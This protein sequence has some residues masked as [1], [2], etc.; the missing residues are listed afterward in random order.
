MLRRACGVLGLLLAVVVA[1]TGSSAASSAGTGAPTPIDLGTL[2]GTNSAATGISDTGEVVGQ[3]QVR[4]DAQWHGFAWTPGGGIVDIPTLGGT[5]ANAFGVNDVGEVAGYS[6]LAGDTT[7]HA[8]Y[9]SPGTGTIDVGTLGG[10][11]S[12]IETTANEPT[13]K[14]INSN[15]EIVGTSTLPGE[16]VFHAFVWTRTGGI[17]DLGTLGGS[18][19]TGEAINDNGV[20]VGKSQIAGDAAWH[21]FS[22][23]PAAGMKDL[24]TS[25][26]SDQFGDSPPDVA[27]I[28]A[29]GQVAGLSTLPGDQTYDAVIW[30]AATGLKDL[31]TGPGPGATAARTEDANGNVAGFLTSA[32][33]EHHAMY[34]SPSGGMVDLGTLG[35]GNYSDASGMNSSGQVVGQALDAN[36]RSH[37]FEWTAD[38]GMIDLPAPTSGWVASAIE[39]NA[40][41][42]VVGA[43]SVNGYPYTTHAVLWQPVSVPGQPSSVTA[44]AGPESAAVSWLAPTSDGGSSITGYTVTA[45][46]ATT[47]TD[48]QP[49]AV[50][51]TS[52]TVSNL[53]DGHAYTFTVIAQNLVG[54]GPSSQPSNQVVP[55][56]ADPTPVSVTSTAAASTG[57]TASTGSDPSTTGGV[58]TTVTVP[59][60]TGGGT[61]TVTQGAINQTAPTGYS[62]GGTQV[63]ITAPTASVS[64]PLS[65]VFTVALPPGYPV[66]PATGGP[67]QAT[68]LATDIYRAE[69]SG[70]PQAIPSCVSTS[71]IDP[72]P[73]CVSDRSAVQINGVWYVRVTVLA[74][75]ASHWNSARPSPAAVTVASGGYTPSAAI[76]QI[77]GRVNWTFTGAKQHSVTDSAALGASSAPLFDSGSKNSGTYGY[78]FLAAGNYGYKSTVKGDSMTG[79]VQVP[80][81]VTHPGSTY[82]VVWAAAKI[83]GYVFDVQYRF[84]PTGS[85]KWGSWTTWQNGASNP[86]AT[87]TPTQGSGTYS[88]HARIRNTTTGKASGDSPEATITIP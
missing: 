68:I 62:F 71:P 72:L 19:S 86:D 74:T 29:S 56:A 55:Q 7:T 26:G 4:G 10:T 81:A 69:G 44:V 27:A 36:N 78:A 87:F 79:S 31:G 88:F 77:G 18:N 45:H 83:T 48:G 28:N 8:F 80:I 37:A 3:S 9:W 34:W 11:Y 61:I 14:L 35:G 15:G 66:D 47:S 67:D 65:L 51:G 6:S 53:I 50:S 60:G 84:K 20:V 13:M 85:T 2:G 32:A 39:I 40:N 52:T 33:N 63:D 1:V 75:S 59:P 43:A 57:G 30:T 23:T 58:T 46:D 49:L 76:V 38:G 12:I 64:S 54:S 82:I 16:A 73:A 42:A 17:H 24:T 5:Y 21:I 70:T 25:P 41:G 22:W